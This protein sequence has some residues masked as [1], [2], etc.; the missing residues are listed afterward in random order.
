MRRRDFIK[1]LGGAAVAWPLAARAQQPTLPVIGYLNGG[2]AAGRAATVAAFLD[3]LKQAGFTE[4]ANVHVE[5]RWADYQ[6][7][8]LPQL[9]A[10][11]VRRRVAVIVTSGAP[12]STLAAKAATLTIPIVFEH[13][14]DPV[15]VGLVPRMNRPGGNV[16]GVTTVGR[17]TNPKRLEFLRELVPGIKTLGFLVNPG[18]PNTRS[19]IRE[20]EARASAGGFRLQVFNAGNEDEIDTAFAAMA[21]QKVDAFVTS[22]DQVFGDRAPQ[23]AALMARYRLPGNSDPRAGGLISYGASLADAHRQVALYVAR[24]LKGEKAGDLPVVQPT[25]FDLVINLKTAKALGLTV[26]PSL[27]ATADE[28]IE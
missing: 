28:V 8:L 20:M 23:I 17:E 22:I 24:I 9:A 4:G 21:Q 27:L 12:N 2:S 10:D 11:L 19:E 3:G 5:F 6:Y 25:K 18:N 1:L 26:S 7:D 16:T 15:E 14:S 13:G